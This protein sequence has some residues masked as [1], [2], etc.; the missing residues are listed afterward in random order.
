MPQT[1]WWLPEA[2]GGAVLVVDRWSFDGLASR[3]AGAAWA[4]AGQ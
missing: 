1:Q 3:V 4:T 2:P